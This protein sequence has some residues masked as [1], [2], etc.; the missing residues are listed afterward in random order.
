MSI[1]LGTTA[2]RGSSKDITAIF[3]MRGTATTVTDRDLTLVDPS[4]HVIT[5]Y[6]PS[7]NVDNT[8]TSPT[9]IST[10]YYY[11][12]IIFSSSCQLGYWKVKWAATY[13][14]NTWPATV[15]IKVID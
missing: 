8:Y 11:Q 12:S 10:G 2:I 4:S 13:S 9:K 15:L 5:V 7:G 14:G 6:D 1:S 3:R